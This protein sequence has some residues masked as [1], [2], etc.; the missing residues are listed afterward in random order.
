MKNLFLIVILRAEYVSEQAK[1]YREKVA[2]MKAEASVRFK[3][4]EGG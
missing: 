1:I 4:Y 3:E 2:K